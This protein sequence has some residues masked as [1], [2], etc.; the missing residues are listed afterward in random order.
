MISMEGTFPFF[1]ET[2]HVIALVGAGGKTTL[3]YELARR[4]AGR[5][6]KVLV[7]TTT[8]IHRPE[9]GHLVLH[10]GEAGQLWE[11]GTYAVAGIPCE[12]GKL[13]SLSEKELDE[14][15]Q[16]ADVV[17]I[18][19]DGSKRM[20]CKVPASH[21]PVIPE[22]CDIVIG[23]MG[24]RAWGRPLEEVC[25]RKEEAMC[26]LGVKPREILDEERMAAILAAEDGTRKNV[27]DRE[28]CVVLSQCE[29]EERMQAAGRIRELL[30]KRH[31]EHC[32]IRKEKVE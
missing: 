20:P 18:E 24:M 28:Y 12:E 29:T 22:S 9:D 10:P 21:E 5:G 26:L 16:M 14:Y 2:G 15:I 23:V 25:F 19:A 30:K 4:Y 11:Q 17:L 13:C 8:H 3:M 32:V 1:P 31:I 7:T 27:G 6:A